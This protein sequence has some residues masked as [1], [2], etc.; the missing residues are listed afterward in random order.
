MLRRLAI[1]FVL[2]L[3]FSLGCIAAILTSLCAIICN[4]HSYGK[5]VLR[6]MDKLLAAAVFGYPGHHTL[7]AHLGVGDKHQWL[8]AI[9]DKIQPGHC[10]MAAID[11]GLIQ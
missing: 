3:P 1:I 6:A 2:W 8:R 4:K 7:S 9:L 10:R 5:D 11:E